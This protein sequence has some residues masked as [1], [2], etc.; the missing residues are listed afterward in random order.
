MT[1]KTAKSSCTSVARRLVVFVVYDNIVLLDLVGPLQVFS[2]APDPAT[3]APGYECVVASVNGALTTTNTV[4][5]IPSVAAET[6]ADQDIHT[7]I[8]VGGDG[9]IPGMRD[10]KLVGLVKTLARRAERVASVC[11]GALV[12]AATGWL[13]GRR[14]VTHWDDC[15]MLAAEFPEVRVELDPIFIKDGPVW[16]SAGITAGIDMALAIVAEDLGRAAAFTVARS[17]VAQMV[18]SGGQSQF[19]PALSRQLRDQAGQFEALH[20]WIAHNLCEDLTVELLA[21]RAGMSPRNF[22]RVYARTMGM[23]PA[24]AVAAMR[25]ERAQGL[26]ETTAQGVK[27]IAASCGF[28]DE[29]RMRRAF[30]GL[31]GVSPSEYRANFNVS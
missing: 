28:R 14:A 21:A 20:A 31:L 30:V 22:A 4:L 10:A 24:K 17:M 11:S 25:L 2:H 9:A 6:L 15:A 5:S 1:A 3:D 8:V 12:L 29:D 26:L 16:T 13:N 23:T 18:R 7:L 27:Q 19:S